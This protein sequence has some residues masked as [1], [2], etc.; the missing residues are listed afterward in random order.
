MEIKNIIKFATN[1]CFELKNDSKTEFN[2][3]RT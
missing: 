1:S 2:Q 3:T